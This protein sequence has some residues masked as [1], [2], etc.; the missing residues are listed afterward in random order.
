MVIKF[1]VL[2]SQ[3]PRF[4]LNYGQTVINVTSI[5]RVHRLAARPT[6]YVY[7]YC[8][9]YTSLQT[10]PARPAV[11][12]SGSRNCGQNVGA[13][14][15][16]IW[17][18]SIWRLRME[19]SAKGSWW[20]CVRDGARRLGGDAGGKYRRPGI[21]VVRSCNIR[22]RDTLN[23]MNKTFNELKIIGTFVGLNMMISHSIFMDH[24]LDV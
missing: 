7:P 5:Y 16:W 6:R 14:D 8:W 12:R 21:R 17:F 23:T 4:W 24:H 13:P 22:L 18:A 20:G 9:L 2:S 3:S 19:L 11:S 1:V 10:I 15:H